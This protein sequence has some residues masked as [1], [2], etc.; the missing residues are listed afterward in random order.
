MVLADG[1][2]DPLH[3]GH[4]KYLRAA[5]AL[6]RPLV[7]NIA[8][9]EAIVAKGRHPFQTRDERALTIL[10]LDMVDRICAYPL[11]VAIRELKPRYFVK[12]AEW[13][14]RLPEEASAACQDVGCSMVYLEIRERTS[15]ERLNG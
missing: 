14:H 8:P 1:C 4:I 2:F 5:A 7:V 15:T 6:G 10:A 3:V 11:A 9:D 12:G 13:R